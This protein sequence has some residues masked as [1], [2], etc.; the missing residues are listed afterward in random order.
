MKNPWKMDQKSTKNQSTM[1]QTSTKNRPKSRSGGLRGRFGG[2]L[3][4]LGRSKASLEASWRRLGGVLEGCWRPLGRSWA[5]KGRQHGSNLAPKTEPKPIKN[6][7]QNW[8]LFFSASWNR[9]VEGFWWILDANMEPSWHQNRSKIDAN[10]EKR[11]FEKSCSRC[12]GGSI[13]EILGVEVGSKNRLKI[14]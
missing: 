6:R 2:L 14:D 11:F 9:F 1:D 12:S 10:C 7:S 4:R 3:G 5:E 13:F 8:W